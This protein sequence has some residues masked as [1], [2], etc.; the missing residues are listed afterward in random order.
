MFVEF[1]F[2]DALLVE[3]N[4]IDNLTLLCT[5]WQHTSHG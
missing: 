3:F 5:R 4:L 1:N 2:K